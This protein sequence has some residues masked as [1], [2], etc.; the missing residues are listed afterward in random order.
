MIVSKA[1]SSRA[2]FANNSKLVNV[3]ARG[4]AAVPSR[5]GSPYSIVAARNPA[6]PCSNII[7]YCDGSLLSGSAANPWQA[8]TNSDSNYWKVSSALGF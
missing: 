4:L 1:Q 6:D 7:V 8:V 3:F 5:V 2:G